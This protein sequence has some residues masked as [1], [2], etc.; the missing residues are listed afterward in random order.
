MHRE[1]TLGKLKETNCT[2]WHNSCNRGKR[3]GR[4]LRKMQEGVYTFE[5]LPMRKKQRKGSN[6]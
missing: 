1:G 4:G 2:I 3:K 5:A 6:I